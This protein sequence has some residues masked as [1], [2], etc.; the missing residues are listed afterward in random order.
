MNRRVDYAAMRTNQAF[1]IG[2]LV[3][4]FVA[5]GP[6]L[7]AFV[8]LV[9]AVGTVWPRLGLF[10]VIYR[11][12]LRDRLVQPDVLQDNPE[13]HRFSQ[14]FGAVVLLI[15]LGLFLAGT[16]TAAWIVVG[17]VILLAA[18]N[19]FAGFCAGCFLYYWLA[20][21]RISGFTAAPIEGTRPGMAPR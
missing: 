18:M 16:Q 14:G 12:V 2:L 6:W 1:I 21:L 19:L 9:M 15:A 7:V 8:A 3:V 17:V 10:Q 4:A 13:P 20:R 11:S 5:D